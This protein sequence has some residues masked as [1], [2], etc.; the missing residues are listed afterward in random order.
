MEGNLAQNLSGHL[1]RIAFPYGPWDNG[2][3]GRRDERS[4]RT[5]GEQDQRRWRCSWC[6]FE[7]DGISPVDTCP[8]CKAPA[9]EFVE[10]A[11]K[12]REETG[13]TSLFYRAGGPVPGSDN[14]DG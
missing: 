5:V 10:T 14:T 4:G 6:G 2:L 11:R 1:C 3:E 7:H 12:A 13:E 8:V 9:S